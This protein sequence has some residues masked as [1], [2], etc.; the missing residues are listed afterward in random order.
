MAVATK[1]KEYLDQHHIGYEICSHSEAYTAQEIAAA[2]HI[3]GRELAKTVIARKGKEFLMIVLPAPCNVDFKALS[4]E[5]GEKVQ[6]ASEREF[7][8]LFPDCELGAMPPFGNLY[9]LPVYVDATLRED[10]QIDFNAGS[11]R[12]IIRLRFEDFERLVQPKY[13]KFAVPV[14]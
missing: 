3:P 1:L 2:A 4:Q 13:M 11:H 12:E 14:H 5:L 7:Q 10:K 6:L 9:N 8:D